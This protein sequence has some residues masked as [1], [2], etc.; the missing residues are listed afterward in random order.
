MEPI[1][2][3]EFY[4][5]LG[6][7]RNEFNAGLTTAGVQIGA[8]EKTLVAKLGSLKAWGI[9]ALVGGQVGAGLLAGL[10]GPQKV[11]AAAAAAIRTIIGV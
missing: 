9:A 6:A 7:V 2:Q 5:A 4:E 11:T 8:V 10:V 1:G 3:K